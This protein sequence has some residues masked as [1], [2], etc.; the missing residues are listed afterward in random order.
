[1]W[2][3]LASVRPGDHSYTWGDCEAALGCQTK[4]RKN[5]IAQLVSH[6]FVEIKQNGTVVLKDPYEAFENN[7]LSSDSPVITENE[8]KSDSYPDPK[9][10][11]KINKPVVE[12]PKQKSPAKPKDP[13]AQE[14]VSAII[15]AWNKYK[16]KSYQKLRSV[17]IKQWE[18]FTKQ[19][20]NLNKTPADIDPF[21]QVVC[22]GIEKSDFWSNKVQQSGRNFSAI[23][24]YGNA[25][26]T[27]LKNVEQLY[28]LGASIESAKS[29]T[30]NNA[31]QE[32]I[33]TYKTVKYN[34]QNA[35]MRGDIS[36][37]QRWT[38]FLVAAEYRLV[39]NGVNLDEI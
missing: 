2:L 9:I 1:M 3:W 21:L 15:E 13:N 25:Q 29:S 18:A 39:S 20:K 14:Y 17:S 26:D 4:A 8:L 12:P 23:F 24:G 16:P 33:S 38:D 31:D 22:S 19:L 37:I 28:E 32:D 36:E 5:C 35:K 7:N 34:L 6:G 27:K 30:S 10:V 11:A